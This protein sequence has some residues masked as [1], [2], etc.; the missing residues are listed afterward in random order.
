MWSI[1]SRKEKEEHPENLYRGALPCKT[2]FSAGRR[3]A[4]ELEQG[5]IKS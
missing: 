1:E 3:K 4:V 5:E 2:A